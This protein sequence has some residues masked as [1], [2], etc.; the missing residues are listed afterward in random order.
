MNITT[1][2][3]T[4]TTTDRVVVMVITICLK[5]TKMR[6]KKTIFLNQDIFKQILIK[7]FFFKLKKIPV[8]CLR[9]N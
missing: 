3:H 1:A 6:R 7:G 2:E 5:W 4:M 8:I 9:M